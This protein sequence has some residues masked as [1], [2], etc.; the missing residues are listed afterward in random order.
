[1]KYLSNLGVIAHICRSSTREADSG[2]LLSPGL[3]SETL[4]QQTKLGNE[5]MAQ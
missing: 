3:P 1:M 2:E 4:S 5:E